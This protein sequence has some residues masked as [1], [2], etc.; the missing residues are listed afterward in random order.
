MKKYYLTNKGYIK[1]YSQNEKVI[2]PLIEGNRRAN[3]EIPHY[4]YINKDFPYDE[5]KVQEM[6][7]S[8]KAVVPVTLRADGKPGDTP[9]GAKDARKG[10]P[11]CGFYFRNADIHNIQ[12]KDFNFNAEKNEEKAD[13]VPDYVVQDEKRIR[14][15]LK[16]HNEILDSN[17]FIVKSYD[18]R[19]SSPRNVAER[20]GLPKIEKGS[21]EDKEE[22]IVMFLGEYENFNAMQKDRAMRF[23]MIKPTFKFSEP[24]LINRKDGNMDLSLYVTVPDKMSEGIAMK[25]PG[26]KKEN[27]IYNLVLH[28]T[29]KNG[30]KEEQFALRWG[31]IQNGKH[32]KLTLND[33]GKKRLRDSICVFAEQ[34]GH[35]GNITASTFQD[36]VTEIRNRATYP[37]FNEDEKEY[38]KK[39]REKKEVATPEFMEKWFRSGHSLYN[40]YTS[41][42]ITPAI[43]KKTGIV[44]GLYTLEL[45]KGDIKEIQKMATQYQAK[46]GRELEDPIGSY[47][48]K[49]KE[50]KNKSSVSYDR[51]DFI[52]AN[53]IKERAEDI[54]DF[55]TINRKGGHG[56]SEKALNASDKAKENAHWGLDC[57]ERLTYGKRNETLRQIDPA[58]VD[59]RSTDREETEEQTSLFYTNDMDKDA[60]IKMERDKKREDRK[61][62]KSSKKKPGS[63]DPGDHDGN[64]DGDIG[65]MPFPQKK[66]GS[67]K[68]E[69]DENKE[70]ENFTNQ[71]SFF[72]TGNTSHS[73][74]SHSEV[75][76]ESY[77]EKRDYSPIAKAKKH[78]AAMR[79][80]R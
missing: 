79:G 5:E 38:W 49:M 31:D 34:I 48:L 50:P 57:I 7:K 41:E 27:V 75:S 51:P 54:T 69:P 23:G 65:Q 52:P 32:G 73:N 60:E 6:R 29:E 40:D 22:K 20:I 36:L 25:N 26:V 58:D 78:R 70:R 66:S 62:T 42:A 76:N 12:H 16:I 30:K 33:R 21:K 2:D 71:L 24:E 13:E 37:D 8:G 15:E 59:I 4:F 74:S 63:T 64:H 67:P 77:N 10:E 3:N 28:E 55:P 35:N 61:S 68:E 56:G 14:E 39:G 53:K 80:G 18:P 1:E 45:N 43:D 9:L 46:T 72:E 47:I 44:K 17:A 19:S 11:I